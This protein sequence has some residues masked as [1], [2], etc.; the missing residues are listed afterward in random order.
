MTQN[1]KI[2]DYLNKNLDRTITARQALARFGV[3]NLRARI[4]DLRDCGIDIMTA[5][6]KTRSSKAPVA[7]YYINKVG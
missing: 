4:N 1:F 6:R 7:F 3:K 5:M 2:F